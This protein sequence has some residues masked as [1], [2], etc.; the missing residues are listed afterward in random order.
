MRYPSERREAILKKMLP[1]NNKTIKELAEEK[2]ISEVTL[3]N[4]RKGGS[5]SGRSPDAGR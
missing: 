3:Y 1:P 2:G 4:C 5:P